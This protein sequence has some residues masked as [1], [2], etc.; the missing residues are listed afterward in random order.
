MQLVIMLLLVLGVLFA[1]LARIAAM[2]NARKQSKPTGP[3]HEQVVDPQ[4]IQS[5]QPESK[6][7]PEGTDQKTQE[8]TGPNREPVPEPASQP[9]LNE[10]LGPDLLPGSEA[11]AT[12]EEE[13]TAKP[14]TG[15]VAEATPPVTN[16]TSAGVEG[17]GTMPDPAPRSEPK[18]VTSEAGHS[19]TDQVITEEPE[20]VKEPEPSPQEEPA[21]GEQVLPEATPTQEADYSKGSTSATTSPGKRGGRPRD[22]R[23]E[24]R[25]NSD[26]PRPTPRKMARPEI[27]CW[28]REREWVVGVEVSTEND[29]SQ[30]ISVF[31]SGNPL[32][33]VDEE[34]QLWPLAQL[35]GKISIEFEG[36]NNAIDLDQESCLVYRLNS[37]RVDR[38]R[39][40][41]RVSR[42]WYL[43]IAPADWQRDQERAGTPPVLPENTFLDGWLAHFF[44]FEDGQDACIAFVGKGLFGNRGS[45]QFWLEGNQIPDSSE[46]YG[47]LYG[48]ETPCIVNRGADWRSVGTIVV[49]EEGP[50]NGRWRESFKPDPTLQ[51]QPFPRRITR[52]RAGWYFVRFYNTDDELME[53]FDFR[54]VKGLRGISISGSIILPVQSR[55]EETSVTIVHD[56]D[57]IV[58]RSSQTSGDVVAVRTESGTVL[59]VPPNWQCDK[60][61]WFAGY[62][63][64]LVCLTIVVPRLW[65]AAG[66]VDNEPTQWSDTIL[67][68]CEEDFRANSD[69]SIWLK[70]PFPRWA[71]EISIGVNYEYW[72]AYTPRVSECLV[73]IPLREFGTLIH[74]NDPTE[75]RFLTLRVCVQGT[76]QDTR[77]VRVPAKEPESDFD[78]TQIYLRGLVRTITQ[79][80]RD[81]HG[82]MRRL[83]KEVRRKY[84]RSRRNAELHNDEF[85]RVALCAMSLWFVLYPDAS[86]PP[87]RWHRI[88]KRAAKQFPEDMR[89]VWSRFRALEK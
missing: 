83:F 62:D 10:E 6:S 86:V 57:S 24:G 77:I 21:T 33:P 7:S 60:S 65:W 81:T 2:T 74:D 63:E 13:A 34:S 67:E 80:H 53:S 8:V 71:E 85:I 3:I 55:Y 40:V 52:K 29:D 72:R 66:T 75:D 64:R 78:L 56:S 16:E 5:D 23:N 76:C 15:A 9:V 54:Y 47:P 87:S 58:Q 14:D 89:L 69:R 25:N 68:V 32:A 27:V 17:D 43:V 82:P 70:M 45:Q 50:G 20:T 59:R 19:A 41:K 26:E 42:G 44:F 18:S 35:N 84:R 61:E 1:V 51:A 11:E 38:G 46:D 28:K 49:G 22:S 12:V 37:R 73:T 36:G 30:A 31:Q 79:L 39:L 4:P 88:V 48:G